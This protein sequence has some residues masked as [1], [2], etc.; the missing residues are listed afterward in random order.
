MLYVFNSVKLF[1]LI[2]AAKCE[3]YSMER[4]VSRVIEIFSTWWSQ[5]QNVRP[6]RFEKIIPIFFFPNR[7]I[8]IA[9]M[10]FR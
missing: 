5:L 7:F 2:V 10:Q 9:L 4:S 6:K 1:T 3:L 8:E